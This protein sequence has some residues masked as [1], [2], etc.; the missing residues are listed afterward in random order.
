[1]KVTASLIGIFGAADESPIYIE[2]RGV[3]LESLVAA[4]EKVFAVTEKVKGTR[5][6]KSSWEEGQPE[7]K[8]AIDREKA[9]SFGLTI[10]EV[11]MILR[12]A[13]EG[14]IS[15]KYKEGDTEYDI[16]IIMAKKNRD[17]PADVANTT[18]QNRYGQLIKLGDF[19]NISYGRGPMQIGRKDR[20]RVITIQSNMDQT[21]PLN[22][23][24]NDVQKDIKKLK[25][26]PDVQVHY[27]GA[28]E[29]MGNMFRDMLLAIMLAVLFVY[30]IMVSLFESFIHPFTIM[31]AL[32]VAL[33]G[34]LGGLALTGQNLNIFSMIGILMSMGLVTKNAILLVD[35]TNTLRGQ[36]L[37]MREALLEAG[38]VR[39]RP[40][41]MTT[42]TMVFGMMPLAL[43]LGSGG[44]FRT[45][46][47]IVVIGA[48]V[49]ST[50]LTLVLVPV[51]Y[52]YM[53][54]L[55][56]RFPA[57]FRKVSLFKKKT[58]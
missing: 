2:V 49:S 31:F 56:H 52:T 38:P 13:F 35:Y 3:E 44:E 12:N 25:L 29:D 55:R 17:N 11:A 47:A 37:P 42:A 16:R 43:G 1:M 57:L 53:E 22:E 18:I 41:I 48:L 4:S 51:V 28:S 33:F 21:R 30:M 9:A 19:V 15:S 7:I 23:I 20:S 32:P 34:A 45:G 6:V 50:L 10:G 54:S 8:I 5:D 26:P 40:I 24:M 58:I 36:G 14:E 27:A 46:L 39:L